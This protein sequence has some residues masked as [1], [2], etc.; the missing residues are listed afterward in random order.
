MQYVAH[1]CFMAIIGKQSNL[2]ER[3]WLNSNHL[4]TKLSSDYFSAVDKIQAFD[5]LFQCFFPNKVKNTEHTG[6]N[7]VY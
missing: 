5:G 1:V 2:L 4:P 6:K 7:I 3:Q